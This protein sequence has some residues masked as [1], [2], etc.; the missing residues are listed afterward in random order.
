MHALV[1]SKRLCTTYKLAGL[2]IQ[3]VHVSVILLSSSDQEEVGAAWKGKTSQR[4]SASPVFKAD[5]GW[6][7]PADTWRVGLLQT[8]FH[9]LEAAATVC[10]HCVL[11]RKPALTPLAIQNQ[12]FRSLWATC[13]TVTMT[14]SGAQLLLL[15]LCVYRGWGLQ[16]SAPRVRLS[17]K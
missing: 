9:L 2:V 4:E 15:A 10:L 7:A 13:M 8:V 1:C 17:F 6:L 14:A 16:Q 12:R 3:T 5:G 11:C